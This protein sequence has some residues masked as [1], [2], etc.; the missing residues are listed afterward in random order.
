MNSSSETPRP[1]QLS[2]LSANLLYL[3]VMCIM[4][5]SVAIGLVAFAKHGT[6]ETG[7]KF[8][9]LILVE[10]FL[11]LAPALIWLTVSRVPV[12]ESLRLRWPGW[13]V[14]AC[15]L[16]IGAGLYPAAFVTTGLCFLVLCSPLAINM[17]PVNA[18]DAVMAFIAFAVATPIC[19]EILFRGVI[20]RAYEKQG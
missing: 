10:V 6:P 8:H 5:I 17:E 20:Q 18:A 12:H 4:S 13:G 3:V 19:E 11:I 14:A 15:S 7:T 1:A 16:A 2:I 9:F